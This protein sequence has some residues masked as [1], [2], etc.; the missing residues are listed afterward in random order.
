S[1]LVKLLTGY[2]SKYEGEIA[3]DGRDLH[4]LDMEQLG[5]LSATIHQNI[6]L[7]DETIADN[8]CLHRDYADEELRHALSISGVDLFLGADAKSLSDPVGENGANL[9]GGQRQRIA[10]ARALIL[11]KPLLILDE[12]T[13]SLDMQ[14]AYDIEGRLLKEDDLTLI[15]ITHALNPELLQNY[16][17]ILLM[18]NGTI[19]EMGTY[20]ELMQKNGMFAA[21]SK[22]ARA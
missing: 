11:Q 13:S 12:G 1:T 7:F 15:T 2:Y 18:E 20:A 6:Y 10:V 4:T 9:S 3:Y 5:E 8:I 19:A 17:G 21:Y 14:T 22:L 16:D